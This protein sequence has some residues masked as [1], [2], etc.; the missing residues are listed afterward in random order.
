MKPDEKITQ[1]WLLK[2]NACEQALERSAEELNG[3][4][5]LS[6]VIRKLDRADW[7]LWLLMKTRSVNRRQCVWLAALSA[8]RALRFVMKGEERPRLAIAA[9]EAWAKVPSGSAAAAAGDAAAAAWAA[10]AAG[11]AARDAAGAAA[12]DAE[13]RAICKAIRSELKKDSFKKLKNTDVEKVHILRHALKKAV[14]ELRYHA[15]GHD[16]WNC[17]YSKDR[18]GSMCDC[19]Q[20]VMFETFASV[21]RRTK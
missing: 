18:P 17:N 21:L 1:D 12:R 5:P 8:R 14:K 20:V 10:W 3:G 13:H 6:V 11:D 9:A 4:L 2:N 7:L 16:G 19:G 15:T